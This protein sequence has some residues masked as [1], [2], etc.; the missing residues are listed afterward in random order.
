MAVNGAVQGWAEQ[1]GLMP[2]DDPEPP[3]DGSVRQRRARW[4]K[5][6]EQHLAAGSLNGLEA[7][8]RA[9]E[10]NNWQDF[11]V[12]AAEHYRKALLDAE[13]ISA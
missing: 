7:D 9:A 13:G 5:T 3:A 4:R 8:V 11:A 2:P 10:D 6:F 1:H 12:E